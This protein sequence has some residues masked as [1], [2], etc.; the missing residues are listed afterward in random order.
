VVLCELAGVTRS[1]A[2]KR[3]GIPEGT[4]SSRLAEA[5][6]RL[7]RRLQSWGVAASVGVL[8]I[9]VSEALAAST[10]DMATTSAVPSMAVVQLAEA[11]MRT[12][13]FTTGKLVTVAALIVAVVGL[14]LGAEPSKTKVE[15]AKPQAPEKTGGGLGEP[16]GGSTDK[17]K[18]ALEKKADPVSHQLY[19]IRDGRL[20]SLDPDGSNEQ[21]ILLSG[22]I[23]DRTA[24][25]APDG[26]SF[27]HWRD[28]AG[29]PGRTGS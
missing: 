26:L 5:R 22:T 21:R 2:A 13:I 7:A 29:L 15:G 18:A 4:L 28:E 1:E 9:P 10:C 19:V 6:R 12:T 24:Q 11:I 8:T 16:A 25:P 14:G 20:Y 17:K 23:A 3:L 27:A